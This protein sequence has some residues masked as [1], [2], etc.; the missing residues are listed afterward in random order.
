MGRIIDLGGSWRFEAVP[1]GID[2]DSLPSFLTDHQVGSV[3]G[4]LCECAS[5]RNYRREGAGARQ[6]ATGRMQVPLP[7]WPCAREVVG[8]PVHPPRMP[9]WYCSDRGG[10]FL[11]TVVPPWPTSAFQRLRRPVVRVRAR[12]GVGFSWVL[13][14]RRAGAASQPAGRGSVARW[15]NVAVSSCRRYPKVEAAAAPGDPSGDV[16]EPVAEFYDINDFDFLRNAERAVRVGSHLRQLRQQPE[17]ERPCPAP[18]FHP[19]E[20]PRGYG[21]SRSRTSPAGGQD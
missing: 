6:C 8:P 2:A 16:R 18:W 10:H 17:R 4:D 7:P 13:E 11:Q 9:G 20:P 14:P 19:G 1:R 12:R 15:W 21:S 5:C 3:G